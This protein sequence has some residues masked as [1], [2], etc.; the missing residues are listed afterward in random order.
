[1]TDE[2]EKFIAE[3]L[4]AIRRDIGDIKKDL[5]DVTLRQSATEH[6]E[7]GMM[8]HFA[9]MHSAIDE[10]KRDMRLVK[11]RLELVGE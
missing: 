6:F 9:S 10:L 11:S 3:M 8:A 4:Q 5:V 1:M 2:R 7:K